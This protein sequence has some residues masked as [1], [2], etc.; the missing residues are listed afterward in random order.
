[1]IPTYCVFA[2]RLAVRVRMDH[3]HYVIPLFDTLLATYSDNSTQQISSRPN[4]VSPF[5]RSGM[6]QVM[7]RMVHA[8]VKFP[9]IHTRRRRC[10]CVL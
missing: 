1:V 9:Q 4:Q 8:A 5:A 2:L 7:V 6:S 3:T 10:L